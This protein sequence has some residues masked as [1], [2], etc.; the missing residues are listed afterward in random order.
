MKL[1]IFAVA[2]TLILGVGCQTISTV[3][4]PGAVPESY[5]QRAQSASGVSDYATALVIYQKFLASGLAD[6]GYEL[7]AK[8]EIAFL[9]YKMGKKDLAKTEF[10]DILTKYADP[11]RPV[12]LPG[13]VKSLSELMLK[14][15]S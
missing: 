3:F 10:Q 12:A 2:I 14:K 6:V 4:D 15:V 1:I 8:Y 7:S 13:W 9:H 11:D 5:F